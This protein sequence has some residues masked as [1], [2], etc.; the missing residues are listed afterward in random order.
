MIQNVTE[1]ASDMEM[2]LTLLITTNDLETCEN[3]QSEI[4]EE[5]MCILPAFGLS[6]FQY[7]AYIPEEIKDK[8]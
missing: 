7:T 1:G 8:Q 3:I 6:Q 4:F 2:E 5:I